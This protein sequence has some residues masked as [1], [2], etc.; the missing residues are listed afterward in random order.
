M[1]SV[2]RLLSK[3]WPLIVGMLFTAGVAWFAGREFDWRAVQASLA[4]ADFSYLALAVV[5]MLLDIALKARRWQWL[6]HPR[7]QHLRWRDLLCAL[8]VG[9]LGNV[10]LPT[11]LGD[12]MRMA[13]VHTKADVPLSWALATLV[14]EKAMDGIMLLVVLG[15]LLPFVAWPAWLNATHTAVGALLAVGLVTLTWAITQA[16]ARQR[17]VRILQRMRLDSASRWTQRS[18]QSLEAWRAV[19]ERPVQLRLWTL[20]AVIWLLSGLVNWF[21]YRAVALDLPFSAGLLLAATE[22]AGTRLAY[23][24]AAIGI[25]HSIAVLTLALFGVEPAAALSAALLLHLVVYLPILSGGLAAM[26]WAG[27]DLRRVTASNGAGPEGERLRW[28]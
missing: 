26:W 15:A 20:S 8:L 14:A 6:F 24:P 18:L 16:G 22:I 28:P 23:A 10:L 11:R 12:V 21:G 4:A 1:L 17:I 25:Y 7:S 9:Q 3:S 19:Q 5:A 13:A 27:M 2:R